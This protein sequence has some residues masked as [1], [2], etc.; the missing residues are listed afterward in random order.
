MRA[1]ENFQLITARDGTSSRVIRQ[2]SMASSTSI[3]LHVRQSRGIT[4]DIDLW[5]EYWKEDQ[6]TTGSS[7]PLE[8]LQD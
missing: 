3:S 1:S 7:G 5:T 8:A 2:K 6:Q 4:F